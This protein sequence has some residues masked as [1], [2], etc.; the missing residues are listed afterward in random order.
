M[1]GWA[2]QAILR[3]PRDGARWC[4]PEQSPESPKQEG[5]EAGGRWGAAIS[6]MP[7]RRGPGSWVPLLRPLGSEMLWQLCSGGQPSRSLLAKG[8]PGAGASGT[9]RLGDSVLPELRQ[10]ESQAAKLL[11]HLL[12]MFNGLLQVE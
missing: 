2:P 5:G 3:W 7:P 10:E 9:A 6:A 8:L 4:P 1:E 11:L 12:Q